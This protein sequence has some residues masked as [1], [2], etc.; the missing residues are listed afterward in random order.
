MADF[1]AARLNMVESQVRTADV[2]D[3]RIHDAMRTL[4]RDTFLPAA[5]AHLAYADIVY[6]GYKA[7]SFM[8]C[9]G[10]REFGIEFHTL[11]KSYNM[12]GWRIGYVVGNAEILKTLNKTKSYLDFGIF[13]AVQEAA[14]L[15]R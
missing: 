7:P 8:Q 4:P 1:A 9:K 6:D 15:E 2:T 11:S 12:T 5:K 14:G 10:A 13:R 3:V